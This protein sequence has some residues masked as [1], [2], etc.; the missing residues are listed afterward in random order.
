MRMFQSYWAV[1]ALGVLP[2]CAWAQ[3]AGTAPPAAAKPEAP[4]AAASPA[5]EPGLRAWPHLRLQLSPYTLHFDPDPL[6]KP[7]RLIGLEREYENGKLDGVAVFSNSF[8]QDSAFLYPWGGVY[9]EIWGVRDLSF[10]WMAGVLYGY[11]PPF[12]NKVPGNYKGFSPGLIAGVNYQFTPRWSGQLNW[13]GTAGI[14]FAV[15]IE[16]N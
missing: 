6:H 10:K 11:K 14:M 4:I 16:L 1:V 5:A 7:V 8:G 3:N 2:F 12:E 9:K 15:N 13:L